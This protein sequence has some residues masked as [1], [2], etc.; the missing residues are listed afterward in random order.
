MN[1]TIGRAREYQQL[2]V[3]EKPRAGHF[4]ESH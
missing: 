4:F 1:G 3:P 2:A